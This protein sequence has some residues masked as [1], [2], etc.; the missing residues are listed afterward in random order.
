MPRSIHGS[1]YGV[2]FYSPSREHA[3]D[4]EAPVDDIFLT[5]DQ[6]AVGI[7]VEALRAIDPGFEWKW[8]IDSRPNATSSS[9]ANDLSL[10]S[11]GDISV[12]C[13][14]FPLTDE[15]ER[16]KLVE[17][18]RE[19]PR[20]RVLKMPRHPLG[21]IIRYFT[22][23]VFTKI[24][25]THSQLSDDLANA[26]NPASAS[27][28]SVQFTMLGHAR[29]MGF[30]TPGADELTEF[31]PST[32]LSLGYMLYAPQLTQPDEDPPLAAPC[33]WLNVY[34]HAG[35]ETVVWAHQL[36]FR[37][38]D[39]LEDILRE[40]VPRIV[41]CQFPYP[42]LADSDPSRFQKIRS[43]VVINAAYKHHHWYDYGPVND[44]PFKHA[45]EI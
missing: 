35:L 16:D 32:N 12:C 2:P 39:L 38:R 29:L 31:P 18:G 15:F 11:S 14:R 17:Q 41:V 8:N 42:R 22:G 28:Y 40:N 10:W 37:Y 24:T 45:A 25:R 1:I 7:V 5:R 4:E 19:H 3:L 6:D 34:G 23:Q 26:L 36:R 33:R 21:R 20:L 13:T 9:P 43:R 30:L 44:Q 27:W